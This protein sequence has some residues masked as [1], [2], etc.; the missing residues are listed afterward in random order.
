[1]AL[2]RSGLDDA[3]LRDIGARVIDARGV[4]NVELD[5]DDATQTRHSPGQF[6]KQEVL[7]DVDG[8]RTGRPHP[9]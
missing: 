9:P 5:N 6:A 2:V 8:E 1:M 3:R 4:N 7:R